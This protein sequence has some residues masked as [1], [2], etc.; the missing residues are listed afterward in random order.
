M[1]MNG[2]NMGIPDSAFNN[3]NSNRNAGHIP[4]NI[5]NMANLMTQ[6]GV[7]NFN[8]INVSQLAALLNQMKQVGVLENLASAGNINVGNTNNHN[9]NNNG[10][11]MDSLAFYSN[12]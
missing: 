2:G 8:N 6:L 5:V 10:N 4:L 12:T 11:N 3:D 9:N 1:A 7:G